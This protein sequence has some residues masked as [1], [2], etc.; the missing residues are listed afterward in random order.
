MIERICQN[1]QQPFMIYLAWVK[2]GAGKNCSKACAYKT[3][4]G[5]SSYT[6]TPEHRKQMSDIVLGRDLTLQ[7]R[8]M[9]AIGHARKGKTFDEIYGGRASEVRAKLSRPGEL[10]PNWRGGKTRNRYPYIF[11]KLRIQVFER[12]GYICMNCDM[13]NDEAKTRDSLHRGLTVHHIDYNKENNQLSNLITLCK[14]CNSSANSRR[15]VW[16]KKYVQLLLGA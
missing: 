12:D 15:E 1:C 4:T 10:N 8:R 14:W 16:Q 9:A 11:F 3:R 6:R 13:T 7:Q 5:Q 2:K